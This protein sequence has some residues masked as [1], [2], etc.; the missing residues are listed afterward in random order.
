MS[1]MWKK[2]TTNGAVYS[3]YTGLFIATVLIILSPTV[4]VDIVHKSEKAAGM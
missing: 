4:W 2:F 3:I 1:I